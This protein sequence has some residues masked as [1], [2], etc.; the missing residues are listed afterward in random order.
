MPEVES[1]IRRILPSLGGALNLWSGV[2]MM[3]YCM[4]R[5]FCIDKATV[6]S[7]RRCSVSTSRWKR[8]WPYIALCIQLPR[9]RTRQLGT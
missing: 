4:N 8:C 5:S 9:L 7:V 2:W 1:V 3:K 6:S